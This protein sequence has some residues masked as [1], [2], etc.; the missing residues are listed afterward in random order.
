M[1]NYEGKNTNSTDLM[2]VNAVIFPR[3]LESLNYYMRSNEIAGEEH[4]P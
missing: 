4:V 2:T 1:D 3:C